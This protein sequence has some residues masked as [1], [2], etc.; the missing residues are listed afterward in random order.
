VFKDQFVLALITL[1]TS[2]IGVGLIAAAPLSGASNE[3]VNANNEEKAAICAAQTISEL[4][5]RSA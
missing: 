5:E 3:N 2:T 4:R 1:I